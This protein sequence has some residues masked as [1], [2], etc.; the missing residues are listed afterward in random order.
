M[1]SSRDLMKSYLFH[2]KLLERAKPMLKLE[3]KQHDRN[4]AALERKKAALITPR[5]IPSPVW[6]EYAQE[7]SYWRTSYPGAALF[8]LIVVGIITLLLLIAAIATDGG[9]AP[10]SGLVIFI[11]IAIFTARHFYKQLKEYNN[12]SEENRQ[13]KANWQG[14]NQR[15]QEENQ[16]RQTEHQWQLAEDER[17]IEENQLPAAEVQ[18]EIEEVQQTKAITEDLL[19]DTKEARRLL[20]SASIIP[21]HFRN[22]EAAS[23]FYSLITST[24]ISLDDW[25]LHLTRREVKL[26]YDEIPDIIT[27]DD[28]T[29]APVRIRKKSFWDECKL[30]AE[31]M[32]SYAEDDDIA[33]QMK[34]LVSKLSEKDFGKTEFH[35]SGGTITGGAF[36][37]GAKA[38][39]RYEAPVIMN[40]DQ[41]ELMALLNKIYTDLKWQLRTSERTDTDELLQQLHQDMQALVPKPKED[42]QSWY[43][44]L[45]DI[46]EPFGKLAG[47]A[48]LGLAAYTQFAG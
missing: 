42:K 18:C 30:L 13:R 15:I 2:L 26:G 27:Q 11:V 3:I 32:M 25:I 44:K 38:D 39:I 10:V 29:K 33:I 16:R 17:R 22:L 6:L 47:I 4:I 1:E 37:T 41:E 23:Y 21:H 31:Q 45:N 20:Y 8:G 7:P 46:L 14:Q 9:F 40:D 35:I 36:G 48:G 43:K 28:A 5:E 24:Q 19:E 12:S 34:E